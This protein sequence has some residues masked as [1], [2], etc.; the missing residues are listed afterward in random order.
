[1]KLTEDLKEKIINH[2]DSI[3]AEDLYNTLKDKYKFPILELSID[4]NELSTLT[5]NTIKFDYRELYSYNFVI[6]T[7]SNDNIGTNH[8]Q[9]C[10]NT[11][12]L[13]ET[14]DNNNI[15]LAA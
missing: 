12:D 15:A 11:T 13:I 1:M 2:F 3:S 5:N 9:Y 14:N 4:H 10:N 7:K 6:S 8:V